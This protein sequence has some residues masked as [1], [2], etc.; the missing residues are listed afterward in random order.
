MVF[1]LDRDG[2]LRS[3]VAE[4]RDLPPGFFGDSAYWASQRPGSRHR[5]GYYRGLGFETLD[6][7]EYRARLTLFYGRDPG[8]D[9]MRP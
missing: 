7:G 1:T 5:F 3:N 9:M 2:T 6:I 4:V 8:R